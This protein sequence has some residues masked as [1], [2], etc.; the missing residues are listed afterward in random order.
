MDNKINMMKPL[1]AVVPL[2]N[3]GAFASCYSVVVV[4]AAYFEG[5]A[6]AVLGKSCLVH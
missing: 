1:A 4:V 5:C 2:V 3:A 6:A